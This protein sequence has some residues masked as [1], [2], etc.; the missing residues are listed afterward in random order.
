MKLMIQ[1]P[2][3]NEAET[4]P[5]VIEDL[6]RHIDGVDEIEVLVIDDGSTDG[7]ADVARALGVNHIVR[8]YRNR[9]LAAAFGSGLAA[10]LREGAD[11]IVNTDGDHQYPGRFVAA[12]IEPIVQGRAE[13][14]I[15]DRQPAKDDRCSWLK[16]KLQWLGSMVAGYLAGQPLADPVSGFRA[17]SRE[18]AVGT[19][20]VTGYSYTLDSLLQ[21]VHRGRAIEFVPIETNDATRPSRLFRSLPQFVF[22]SGVTL[23]RLFFMFHALQVLTVLGMLVATIGS[24]PI[25]RFVVLFVLGDGEGHLQSLILGASLM[26]IGGL[27][28]LSGLLADLLAHNRLLAERSLELQTWSE[29]RRHATGGIEVNQNA[30]AGAKHQTDQGD[31]EIFYP[32]VDQRSF[33]SSRRLAFTLLELLVAIAIIGLL[34]GLLLPAVQAA[35]EAGRRTLCKSNLKQIGLSALNFEST[36]QRLAPNG[37]GYRWAPEPG[38]GVGPQQPGGW[39]YHLLPYM[40]QEALWQH[41]GGTSGPQREVAI[42]EMISLPVSTFKCPS[43]PG[44][45]LG[46][47]SGRWGYRN[48]GLPPQVARTDY[49]INEGDFITGTKGEPESLEEGDSRNFRWTDVRQASGVSW[50]R[51]AAR[52][53]D[54]TDGLTHTYLCGEKYV[55]RGGYNEPSDRGYDGSML[56]GVD[57]DTT[58]WT[59]E[60]PLRDD[61]PD[62]LNE[63][64]FGSAHGSVCHMTMC[65]GSVRPVHFDIAREI[66]RAVG[67]RAGGEYVP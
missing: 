1:I 54:I 62:R 18:T 38:R 61:D 63:R 7:T 28:F 34:V 20:I 31:A 58:R 30:L 16:R 9:G 14:V 65:D 17:L 21:A 13:M 11:I 39:I 5:R 47:M 10:S 8:H 43:R 42:A 53:A 33:A 52:L 2:C 6:P 29:L 27:I 26:V 41:G 35:R 44:T 22:R 37:W 51:G 59:L 48:A 46:F 67:T 45:Q 19:H 3:R 56:S 4:L 32:P 64:R 66:H 50:L 24:L 55:S 57:L 23:L 36:H 12:L 49:A 40:E 15:G 25:V 60:P